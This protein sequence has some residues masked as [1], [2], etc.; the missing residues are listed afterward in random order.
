MSD[1]FGTIYCWFQSLW[2]DNLNLYLWGYEPA[3]QSYT[4]VNIYN[5]AGIITSVISLLIVLLYYYPLSH[6]RWSRWWSWLIALVVNGVLGLFVTYGISYSKYIN[7]YIP[8]ELLY[9]FD[10]EG[11][12]V[13][14]LISSLDC[15]G[16]GIAGFIV[17]TIFFIVFTFIFKW[18]SR[19]AKHVPIF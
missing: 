12:I 14:Y 1:F 4:G 9:E 10:S 6:P 8:Q 2:C 7:G 16:F 15:W 3:T 17:S 13:S 19:D 11:N 18:W 5:I